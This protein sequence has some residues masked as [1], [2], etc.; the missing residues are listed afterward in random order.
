M[1]IG[2]DAPQRCG[3]FFFLVEVFKK[4][5]VSKILDQ[6]RLKVPETDESMGLDRLDFECGWVG[7]GVSLDG[8]KGSISHGETLFGL[9]T[10]DGSSHW[11][12]R[13]KKI[14]ESLQQELYNILYHI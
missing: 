6:A 14:I 7:V 13:Q 3:S 10:K 1:Y 9:W 11:I 2:T 4:Y 5:L 12:L 8:E